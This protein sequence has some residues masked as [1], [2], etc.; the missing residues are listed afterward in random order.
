MPVQDER[1]KP[2][3]LGAR[4]EYAG[5]APICCTSALVFTESPF[6]DLTLI[7]AEQVGKEREWQM[8]VVWWCDV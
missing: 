3:N 6:E 1:R 5:M 7:H 4:G 8:S 2:N